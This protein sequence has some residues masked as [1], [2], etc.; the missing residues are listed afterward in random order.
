MWRKRSSVHAA[1][2]SARGS[3]GGCCCFSLSF[4]A[5]CNLLD[6]FEPE[7]QLIFRKSLCAPA[8]AV[9]AQLIDDLFQ[10][11]G[12]RTLGQQHRLQRVGVVGER[13]SRNH[14]SIR[15]WAALHRERSM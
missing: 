13:V 1:L 2:G 7:Q 9:T 10:P 8:E 5:C 15:S 6:V 12:T 14:E 11:L 3:F 4:S